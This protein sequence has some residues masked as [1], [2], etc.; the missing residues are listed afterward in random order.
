[1]L[2]V[3]KDYGKKRQFF[4]KTS[5]KIIKE[6]LRKVEVNYA[7][8]AILFSVIYVLAQNTMKMCCNLGVDFPSPCFFCSILRV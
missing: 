6:G 4:N 7:Q 1:M 3:R 2:M 5:G 8:L